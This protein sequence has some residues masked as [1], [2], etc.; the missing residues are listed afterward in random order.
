MTAEISISLTDEQEAYARALV[1]AGQYPNVSA[2]LQHGLDMLRRGRQRTTLDGLL[3]RY[4][5]QR[6]RHDLVLDQ[7]IAEGA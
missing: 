2:V 5:P 4:D 6:H 1:E 3:A 7:P